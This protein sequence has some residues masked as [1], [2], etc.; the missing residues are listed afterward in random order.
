MQESINGQIQSTVVAE[1][2]ML[3]N[4]GGPGY[5]SGY[6]RTFKTIAPII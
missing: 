2:S 6:V 3:N 1:L 4:F 5:I